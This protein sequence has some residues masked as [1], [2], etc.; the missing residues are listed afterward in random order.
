MKKKI[1]LDDTCEQE[2]KLVNILQQLPDWCDLET[3]TLYYD[4]QGMSVE[5]EVPEEES[6]A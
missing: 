5:F 6:D 3:V 4:D 2:M 1:V